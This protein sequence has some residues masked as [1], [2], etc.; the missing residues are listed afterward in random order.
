MCYTL[1]VIRKGDGNDMTNGYER[2]KRWRKNNPEKAK[3]VSREWH[4]KCRKNNPEKTKEIKEKYYNKNKG[5]DTNKRQRYTT[6]EIDLI[7]N[8]DLSDI[9]LAKMLKRSMRA[10]QVVRC[11]YKTV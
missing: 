6:E 4:K 11:K 2:L 10:I 9:E 3:E 5:N 1:I 7:L 8:K